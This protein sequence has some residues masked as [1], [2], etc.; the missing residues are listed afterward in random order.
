MT[1]WKQTLV[2]AALMGLIAAAIVWW[3]QTDSRERLAQQFQ[4]YLE[5]MDQ[6]R[7]AYPDPPQPS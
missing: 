6:F 5:R 4:Q 1:T 3:L 7:D 2:A